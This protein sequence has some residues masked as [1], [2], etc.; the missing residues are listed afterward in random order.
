MKVIDVS[1]MDRKQKEEAV[2]EVG[3]LKSLRHPFIVKYLESFMDKKMLC[4]VMDYADGGDLYTQITKH[5]KEGI[6]FDEDQIL[7][8]FV[9]MCMAIKHVHDKKILHRD[10]KTQ[11]IFLTS[12]GEIKLGDFGIARVLQHT[13]D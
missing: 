1:K 3:V 10:L 6:P 11:N 12:K 13:Y 2:N 7:Q 9:Q 4:I 5:K 8:W